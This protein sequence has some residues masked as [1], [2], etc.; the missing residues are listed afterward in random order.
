[1]TKLRL[2]E[3][4]ERGPHPSG[5][6]SVEMCI[7]A[8]RRSPPMRIQAPDEGG[9]WESRSCVSRQVWVLWVLLL[10][11]IIGSVARIALHAG[12]AP[13]GHAMALSPQVMRAMS[14]FWVEA[15]EGGL[16]GAA[17]MV[18][19]VVTLLWLRTTMNYQYK[20]GGSFRAALSHLYQEGGVRRLYAGLAP[21]LIQGPISRFGDTAAN[22]GIRA[23]LGALDATAAWPSAYTSV[24]CSVAAGLFRVLLMPLEVVKTSMQVE[25]TGA[26]KS[27]RSRIHRRGPCVLWEGL[28]ATFAAHFAGHLPWFGTRSL[29]LRVLPAA[30]TV[31][32]ELVRAALIGLASSLVADL[33]SNPMR[34][35]K[36][37]LFVCERERERERVRARVREGMVANN[38]AQLQNRPT[39]CMPVLQM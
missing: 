34:V 32:I 37:M 10:V 28:V 30:P 12:Y 39:P 25:G 5:D 13:A 6:E 35:I 31:E 20:H 38:L 11:L 16:S 27:L 7:E 17:A 21:A 8:D 2:R 3:L 18:V 36:V 1:M 26:L 9:A 14:L 15:L 4:S 22:D 19:Q 33:I 23:A 29:L 24:A